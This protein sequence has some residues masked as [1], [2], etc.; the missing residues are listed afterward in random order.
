MTLYE[1]SELQGLPCFWYPVYNGDSK[2]YALSNCEINNLNTNV[3][4]ILTCRGSAG[5][6]IGVRGG[7]C[8]ARNNFKKSQ[9]YVILRGVW[10]GGRGG[11]A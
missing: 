6:A 5:G 2:F 8:Y 7:L 4:C 11:F 3:T 9:F 1:K 10:G